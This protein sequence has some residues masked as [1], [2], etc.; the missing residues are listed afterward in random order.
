MKLAI[1]PDYIIQKREKNG[2]EI[3]LFFIQKK[4]CFVSDAA[5]AEDRAWLQFGVTQFHLFR[6]LLCD[7]LFSF[8]S[9]FFL[10]LCTRDGSREIRTNQR[11][12]NNLRSASSSSSS[13][14]LFFFFPSITLN[15]NVGNGCV[16]LSSFTSCSCFLRRCT[17]PTRKNH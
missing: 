5:A 2:K 6:G 4:T 12:A 14:A 11:A 9:F 17:P 15:F 1:N 13:F 3:I 10:P 16:E 7:A 8:F